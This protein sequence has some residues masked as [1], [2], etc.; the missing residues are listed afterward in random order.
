M[1]TAVSAIPKR[2]R[3][4]I[5]RRRRIPQPRRGSR[6]SFFLSDIRIHRTHLITSSAISTIAPTHSFPGI[7]RKQELCHVV[8]GDP[9]AVTYCFFKGLFFLVVGTRGPRCCISVNKSQ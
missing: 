1:T 9:S 7:P 4:Q 8:Q 2:L 3:P 6:A 5:S